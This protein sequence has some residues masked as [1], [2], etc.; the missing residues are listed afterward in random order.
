MVSVL[1]CFYKWTKC[2]GS[3]LNTGESLRYYSYGYHTINGA[4]S[5]QL[6]KYKVKERWPTDM[7]FVCFLL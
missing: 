2:Y 6:S 1:F 7:P 5:F 4:Y 3:H